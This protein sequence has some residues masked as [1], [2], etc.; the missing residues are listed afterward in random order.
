MLECLVDNDSL[1]VEV[2]KDPIR[3][4]AD[5]TEWCVEEV[6]LAYIL[7]GRFCFVSESRDGAFEIEVNCNDLF[8]WGTSDAEPLPFAQIPVLYKAIRADPK[9][10]CDKWACKQRGLRPQRLIEK[11]WREEGAWDAEMEALPSSK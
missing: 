3:V 1:R 2:L 8:Y 6:A 11:R 7:A 10:G 4:R 5:G 9:R